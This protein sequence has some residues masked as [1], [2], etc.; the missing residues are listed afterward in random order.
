M[1]AN[2]NAANQKRYNYSPSAMLQRKMGGI[3][4]QHASTARHWYKSE[5]QNQASCTKEREERQLPPFSHASY[6]RPPAS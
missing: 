6:L 1:M 5:Q 4:K 2:H 3:V